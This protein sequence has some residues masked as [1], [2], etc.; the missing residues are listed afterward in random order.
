MSAWR[1]LRARPALSVLIAGSLA[2]GI[3]ANAVLFAVVDAAILRP[4]PFP[5]PDR[6]VGVGAAYPRLNRGLDF[7]EVLSGPEYAAIKAGARTIDR[8]A[9]FDLGNEPV[10]AGDTPERVFTGYFWDDA[11]PTLGLAPFAGR[12]FSE[13]ELRT[14]APVAIVSYTFWQN[15]LGG[16]AAA[17]GRSL[18]VGGRPHAI[19]G[20]MPP[21]T[22]I[23][24]TDLWVPMPDAAATLPQ[25]RRQFNMLARLAPGVDVAAA[26]AE[27]SALARQIEREHGTALPEYQ[28]FDFG[29][30]PW[31]EIEVWGFGGIAGISFAGAAFLLLLITANLANLLLARA[32]D[33]RREMAVR[34]ALGASRGTLARMVASETAL[35]T[36]C[37]AAGGL[38]LAWVGVRAAPALVGDFL[39]ADAVVSLSGRLVLFVVGVSALVAAAVAIAPV[40][41]LTRTHPAETLSAE[42]V[43]TAGSRASRRLQRAIV[44]LQV[45]IA[46]IVTGSAA[47]LAANVARV[48]RVD[49]GFAHEDLLAMRITLPLPRY[50]GGRSMVFFDTLMERTRALPAVSD[51]SVSNQ[52]PPGLFSR[53]QFA[54]EGRPPVETL[55][56]AFFTTAGSNYR[57]TIGLEL[58]G[59]R[60]FD[61]RADRGGPREVVIN[62]AAAAQFFP[63]RNPVGQRLR[64]SPPHSDGTPTEIVGVVRS[65]R[66]RGLARDPAPEIIASVRQIPDRRQSQLYLV[67]RGRAGTA[68]ILNDVRGVMRALDPEQPVYAVST[69]AS[70]YREGVAARRAAAALLGGFAALALALAALGIYG[71]LSHAVG[72]RTREIGVRAALGASRA[73][74]ARMVVADALRPV[75][76]GVAVGIGLV[77]AGAKTLASWVFGIS[78]EPAALAATTALLIAVGI[79]ASLLPARRASKVDPI[80]ALRST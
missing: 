39:P 78:P 51:A 30:R 42:G 2:I 56:S 76:A 26:N 6:L 10:L 79:I 15:T 22:R 44:A 9:G 21:R 25:N 50:E 60:W 14:A 64:I 23:Y 72:T 61:E 34:T 4:F 5:E 13:E 16:D 47:L 36:A 12:G 27:L 71:V 57:Q 58:A 20:I 62:E 8:M 55:P 63:D 32:S 7:F 43:R 52:P 59:G 18:R 28:G 48:L 3:A 29:A 1:A 53:A 46:V 49:P 66:N 11:F 75:L 38:L 68:T 24:G 45:A 19:V 17:V 37:G 74:L 31:T 67:A 73:S 41:Q 35:L 40:L 33:R 69:I 54:V 80:A 70:D 77:L 65:I